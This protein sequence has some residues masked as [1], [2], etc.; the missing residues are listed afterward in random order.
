MMIYKKYASSKKSPDLIRRLKRVV[1]KKK[2]K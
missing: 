2:D 1:H